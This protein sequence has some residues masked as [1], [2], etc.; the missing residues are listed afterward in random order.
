MAII[1][2][3]IDVRDESRVFDAIARNFKRKDKLPNP[4]FD[5]ER[6]ESP[7]NTREIDNP[8][9]VEEF[10]NKIIGNFLQEHV[11]S[12][13]KKEAKKQAYKDINTKVRVKKNGGKKSK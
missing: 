7:S 1:S 5:P 13:E 8:E 11:T 4:D 12:F 2:I 9:T 6:P 10:V 3:D